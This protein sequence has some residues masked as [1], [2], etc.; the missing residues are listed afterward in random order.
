LIE[1]RI[2]KRPP[3]GGSLFETVFGIPAHPLLVHAAVVFVPLQI[4]AAFGYA[5]LP[6]FRRRISWAVV[7]LAVVAPLA[8]LFAKL[9]GDAFESRMVE[10]GTVTPQG[11]A[12]ISVH[13]GYGTNTLYFSIGLGVATLALL[14]VQV[15]RSAR[16][17]SALSTSTAEGSD[18]G[19][20]KDGGRGPVV[21]AAV[22]TVAVL[23]LGAFTGYYVFKTGDSGAHMVWGNM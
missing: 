7:A 11:L 16:T 6:F 2:F 14:A 17:A 19:V 22:L 5:F 1:P 21:I 15:G 13:S 4:L 9:S 12:D 8:A 3:Q 10:R 23:V 20:A 18:T